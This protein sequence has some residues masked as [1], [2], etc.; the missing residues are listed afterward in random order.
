MNQMFEASN[1]ENERGEETS[2]EKVK[3]PRTGDPA[4]GYYY[5]DSTGYEIY[6]EE[7]AGDEEDASAGRGTG[8]GPD[9]KPDV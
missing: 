2:V 9:R 3:T 4:Q 8:D 5:D 7:P 6:R 1:D